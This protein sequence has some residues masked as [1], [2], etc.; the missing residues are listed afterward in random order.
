MALTI[1]RGRKFLFS[2]ATVGVCLNLFIPH[3][4]LAQTASAT[5]DEVD[6][7]RGVPTIVVTAERR[8]S[9]LQDTPI[10]I[11][12]IGEDELRQKNVESLLDIGALA[13]N[14]FAGSQTGG[15]GQNGGFFIRGIGQDRRNITFD[16]GVGVYVDGVFQSRSDGG[17]LGI[18]DVERIEVLR[19]P[20]GTLFGKNTIGG[21]IQYITNK[22]SDDLTGYIDGTVGEFDRIDIKGSVNVPLSDSV[23][24]KATGGWLQR[25]GF[26][27]SETD[28]VRL[29]DEDFR[30]GKLQFRALLSDDVTLDI[31]ASRTVSKNNGRA[32]I[33]DLIDTN[34]I[35]PRAARGEGPFGGNV[36]PKLFAVYDDRFE[37]DSPY[38]RSSNLR[39]SYEYKGYD[40]SGT[41]DIG[42]TEAFNIKLITA[43]MDASIEAQSDWDASPVRVFDVT[44]T[45]QLDQF[46]QEIQFSGR[47]FD[48]RLNYVSGLYYLRETPTTLQSLDAAFTARTG[49]FPNP[50]FRAQ[51]Q[52]VDSY[53]AFVQAT[54]EFTDAFSVTAGLR[55]SLDEKS[56]IT[57]TL[58]NDPVTGAAGDFGF[59]ASG[60]DSWSDFSPRLALQY[61]ITPEVMAYASVTKGFRSGGI[62]TA[63]SPI[64]GAVIDSTDLSQQTYDPETVWSYEA[65]LR[66][67]LFDRRARVNLTGFYADYEDQQLTFF[68]DVLNFSLIQNAAS[69]YRLG[70]ELEVQLYPVEGLALSGNLGYLKARYSDVGDAVGLTN[71][72]IVPRSPKWTYSLSAS[73]E[74]PIGDGSLVPST[75]WNYRSRQSTTSTDG[76]TVL[77]DGYGL[78]TAR[79][80]YNAP[81]DLFSI[82]AFA[83]NLTDKQYFIGG[84]DFANETFIG[85]RQLDVGRPREFG[86]NL[87]FNF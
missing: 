61:Q 12:A 19:G 38:L 85:V 79:L 46:S 74:I 53:A 81:G 86:V 78:L 11:T 8:E 10:A 28:D 44:D 73:Y 47:L 65:G 35:A 69:S 25:D 87:R 36:P 71:D 40:I 60:S 52:K 59:R 37:S 7:D 32:F 26:I 57:G 66:T 23:F 4:V 6:D 16:Q 45:S 56:L 76:N 68:N 2:A 9:N 84:I 14:V 62:N 24:V 5:A 1:S 54:M 55:Y 33:A 80:Q 48:G 21:A 42:L 3:A 27:R 63:F 50:R 77:L 49:N 43:Y 75:S 58:L 82:A 20:Q 17:F 39:S 29:G 67:D 70:G 13:P 30:Y 18:I 22:P 41:L 34:D 51:A 72:S 15:G 83:T 31:A 64:R